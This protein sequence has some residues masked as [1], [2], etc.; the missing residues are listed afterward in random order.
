MKDTPQQWFCQLV[1][2]AAVSASAVWQFISLCFWNWKAGSMAPCC[3][4]LHDCILFLDQSHTYIINV[5][6]HFSVKPILAT[7]IILRDRP[8]DYHSPLVTN[9][10]IVWY[11]QHY[12]YINFQRV[13]TTLFYVSLSLSWRSQVHN[14]SSWSSLSDGALGFFED[15]RRNENNKNNHSNKMRW[16]VIL[17]QFLVIWPRNYISGWRRSVVVSALAW[18]TKLID[19]APGYYLDGWLLTGR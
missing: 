8:L 11:N 3:I 14:I 15:G 2:S 6:C 7:R 9:P 19:T 18:S 10:C 17:D 1:R 16:V 12:L 5:N 13:Q 4:S